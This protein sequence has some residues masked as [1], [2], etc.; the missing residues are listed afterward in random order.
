[1]TAKRIHEHSES[2]FEKNSI[3]IDSY[4]NVYKRGNI[5]IEKNL[6]GFHSKTSAQLYLN[7]MRPN[8]AR[9]SFLIQ[10]IKTFLG[11]ISGQFARP[12]FL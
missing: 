11:F 7:I 8:P 5:K 4:E 3:Y 12:N 1:M 9:Y 10:L 6:R 2:L